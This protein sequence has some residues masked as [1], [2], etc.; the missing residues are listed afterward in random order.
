[1]CIHALSVLHWRSFQ[2]PVIHIC[3]LALATGL[4]ISTIGDEVKVSMQARAEINIVCPPWIL[5]HLTPFKIATL[6][7]FSCWRPARRRSNQG[8]QPLLGAG[9]LTIIQPVQL[10]GLL[11]GPHLYLCLCAPGLFW[12]VHNARCNQGCKDTE[13]D[14]DNHNFNQ[15][16]TVIIYG[17]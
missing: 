2:V 5:G 3:I 9:I 15:G 1:M 10:Q 8:L 13:D 4:V 6:P 14:D 12:P 17:R 16:K 7:P 11:N